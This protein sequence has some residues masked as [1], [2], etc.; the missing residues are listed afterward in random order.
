MSLERKRSVRIYHFF[1]MTQKIAEGFEIKRT[2]EEILKLKKELEDQSWANQKTNE[3]I[4]FLYKELEKKNE[5]LKQLDH[6][7]DEFVSNV[8]HELRTPLTI[9]RESIC[10]ITDGLLGE[11]SE[12]QKSYLEK[13]LVNI[14]RLGNII[15]AVLDISKI[16][17]GKL[18]L[19]KTKVNML[20]LVKEVISNFED[21]AKVKGL[22]LESELPTHEVNVLVDQ[23]KIIQVFNNLIGNALKFVERGRVKIIVKEDED[24][25]EC[26][27]W[28][29]GKGIAQ[30]DMYRLFNKFE[31]LGRQYRGGEKGTGLGLAISKGIIELHGGRIYATSE[32]GK[33]SQFTFILPK[34]LVMEGS[35]ERLRN[36][37]VPLIKQFSKFSL[38]KFD[39][40]NREEMEPR[41]DTDHLMNV[42]AGCLYR[43]S[44]QVVIEDES[45]Y[46]L[47]PDIERENCTVVVDRIQQ[48]VKEDYSKMQFDIQV[49]SFPNDGLTGDELIVK[50]EEAR[51]SA[52]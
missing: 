28:D 42:I 41:L 27:I 40:Q 4:K 12:K 29:T 1:K 21:K 11:V 47:L 25:V 3:G 46:V 8:S 10:Q 15:N 48:K 18:E 43:K 16:E 35:F 19:F 37:L 32:E 34:Y 9:I 6:L 13:S 17:K 33:G 2:K 45:L 23:E 49:I 20:N 51:E 14:D 52:S 7:K 39:I 44:D 22:V 38:I 26:H 31:Q 30:K 24:F 5:K 36:L 50:L